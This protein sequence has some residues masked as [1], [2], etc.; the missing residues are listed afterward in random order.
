MKTFKK[1]RKFSQSMKNDECIQWLEQ[2]KLLEQV[3]ENFFRVQKVITK[4][5]K[6]DGEKILILSDTGSAESHL[7]A[8]LGACYYKSSQELGFDSE[9]VMQTPKKESE[10]VEPEIESAIKGLPDKSIVIICVS[11]KLGAIGEVKSFRTYALAKNHRF[12]STTSLGCVPTS[13]LTQILSTIDVDYEEL[14]KKHEEVK[15]KLQK[16][17]RVRVITSQGTDVM[18]Y[19]ENVSVRASDGKYSEYGAGGNIPIGEVYLAPEP[20]KTEG[21]V[22]IDG[23]SR[24]RARTE[25]IKDTIVI[26]IKKGKAV[27]IKGGKEAELLEQSLKWGEQN[28]I[29]PERVRMI[30]ELGIGMNPKAKVIGTTI[31]DEKALGTAHIALGSNSWFGG[32]IKT[33]LHI[34]QVFRNPKIYID[35][36]L[37]EF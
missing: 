30:A 26:E 11:N 31:I 23:S 33:V 7:A 22:V 20:G 4:C 18:F 2:N 16:A 1:D 34:D 28:S 14:Q 36:E 37:L 10:N 6:A 35:G 8:V 5:L 13:Y 25:L 27:E 9:I 17:K 15:S 3:N 32:T 24:N 21:T 29:Y 12:I 19:I